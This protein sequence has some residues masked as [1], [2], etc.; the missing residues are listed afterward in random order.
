LNDHNFRLTS[1]HL[2][3][4]YDPY[5]IAAYAAGFPPFSIPYTEI[6]DLIAPESLLWQAIQG[7]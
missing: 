2:E 6:Q 7:N 4:Y 5:A 3:L 1:D